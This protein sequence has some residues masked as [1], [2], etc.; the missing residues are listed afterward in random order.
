MCSTIGRQRTR[1]GAEVHG[2]PPRPARRPRATAEALPRGPLTSRSPEPF[3]GDAPGES[4]QVVGAP[5]ALFTGLRADD[6]VVRRGDDGGW[7]AMLAGDA[8]PSLV[9]RSPSRLRRATLVLRRQPAHEPRPFAPPDEQAPA[10]PPDLRVF[11]GAQHRPHRSA[12]P[13][14]DRRVRQRRVGGVA[15]RR[16]A[17]IR[18]GR[19][20]VRPPG[21]LLRRRGRIAQARHTPG[22]SVR[23]GRHHQLRAAARGNDGERGAA[24]AAAALAPVLTA[25]ARSWARSFSASPWRRAMRVATA[26]HG[27]RRWS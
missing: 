5:G 26:C 24:T 19:R 25:R 1:S 15:H 27:A 23:G 14:R 4:W 17:A 12:G 13:R 20:D 3:F 18:D 22:D 16:P 9:Y 8:S 11:R 2:V 10:Q 6:V 21:R 7:N